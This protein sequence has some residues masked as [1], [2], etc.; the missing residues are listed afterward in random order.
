MAVFKKKGITNAK[1]KTK[2]GGVTSLFSRGA[3]KAPKKPKAAKV[4]KSSANWIWSMIGLLVLFI[5]AMFATFAY[6]AWKTGHA[7]E[8]SQI[9]G[10][11][12]LLSQQ[13]AT[14]AI[15]ASTG[16]PSAFVQLKRSRDRFDDNQRILEQ[17]NVS[18][19]LPPMPDELRPALSAVSER[20]KNYRQDIDSILGGREA[21]ETVSGYVKE[22]S[23]TTPA[24]LA[25]SDEV[26][27]ILVRSGAAQQDIYVA[28]M[29]LMLIQRIQNNLSRILSGGEGVATAADQFG[30]DTARFERHLAGMLQGNNALGITKIRNGEARTKL[31]GVSDLFSTVKRNVGLILENAPQLFEIGDAA[32]DIQTQSQPMLAD[33]EA[34]TNSVVRYDDS[35]RLLGVVGYAFGLFALFILLLLGGKM[36]GETRRRLTEQR[37]TNESNQNAILTLLDEMGNLADGDLSVHTTVTEEITGAIADSVNYSIDA[38]RELVATINATVVQVSRAV[39][40]SRSTTERLLE[41]TNRQSR[42]IASASSSI[43]DMSDSMK[44]VSADAEASADEAQR[45]VEIA[46]AGGE[47]VRRTISG[48]ETIREQIQETS[49]RIKRLGESSQEIGDIVNLIT[50]ISDQ[51]NILALNAAIQASM[52]GEAG[53]GFAVVADEVQRLAERTGDA[54]K[55]I[56]SLVKTIQADTNEAV[57][58]M[59]QST[60][61]VVK[62]AQLAEDAGTALDEIERTSQSLADRILAISKSAHT[63]AHQ[64]VDIAKS[65]NVIQEITLQ[66]T[67]GTNETATAIGN[68]TMLAEALRESVAGFK[69]P[70][71]QQAEIDM[72]LDS[73]AMDRTAPG[74]DDVADLKPRKVAN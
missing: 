27:N 16:S 40:Q 4:N 24:L 65:M 31:Q 60:T 69:L 15:E 54:T 36:V 19:G 70:A 55:R 73:V 22:I 64:A 6:E 63:H 10:E 67:E 46:H 13:L 57:A 28:T 74:Q 9:A 11:Q 5:G 71:E 61:N 29:Q 59:E 45:S 53:R 51:T 32:D 3:K 48:M 50:E 18:T 66:T 1:G 17:G 44:S 8:Y 23:E 2:G 35:L 58:S 21:I 14:F 26:N 43:T 7:K 47:T 62:G 34:L 20:W 38:L 52:A 37:D 25:T 41:A 42:E 68:L 33:A 30:R 72:V 39:E 49:K 56:E 12:G